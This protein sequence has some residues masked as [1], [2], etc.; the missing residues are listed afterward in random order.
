MLDVSC[1]T[2]AEKVHYADLIYMC[3]AYLYIRQANIF[4]DNN[5][6]FFGDCE[7]INLIIT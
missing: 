5:T 2:L 4:H 7:L 3:L 6:I 1:T